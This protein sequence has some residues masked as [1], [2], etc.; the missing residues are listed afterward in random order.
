MRRVVFKRKKM[1][2]TPTPPSKLNEQKKR[3]IDIKEN[4]EK[5]KKRYQPCVFKYI[6]KNNIYMRQRGERKK[7]VST[8]CM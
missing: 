6:Q 8:V 7:P 3:L 4:A 1:R 2:T 5:E